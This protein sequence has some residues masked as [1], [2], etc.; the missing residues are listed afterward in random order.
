MDKP[1][2]AEAALL[3]ASYQTLFD[4]A[5][6]LNVIQI[7]LAD[8]EGFCDDSLLLSFRETKMGLGPIFNPAQVPSGHGQNYG[9]SWGQSF[10]PNLSDLKSKS[11]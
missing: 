6:A 8:K 5:G 1:E 4:A 9:K 10:N 2:D 7:P 3:L 11:P